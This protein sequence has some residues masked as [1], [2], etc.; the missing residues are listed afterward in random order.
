MG[1]YIDLLREFENKK[2]NISTTTAGQ[3]NLRVSVALKE[4]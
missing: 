2:R 3:V 4:Y 1:E